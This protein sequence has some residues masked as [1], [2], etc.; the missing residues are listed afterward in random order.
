MKLAKKLLILFIIIILIFS[1]IKIVKVQNIFLKKMYPLEHEEYVDK[2][3]EEFG[4]DKYYI[5]AIIKAESNYD[6]QAQSSK[7]AMGLMQLLPTT[8]TEVANNLEIKLL[9]G[10]L[11]SPEINIMIGTKY[12][13]NLHKIYNN[14]M[15]AIAAYNA[16]PGT[17]NKWIADGSIEE[18]GTNIENIPYKETNMYVRKII[19]NYNIYKQLYN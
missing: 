12:F 14:E 3:S 15:L 1:L 10:T 9:E 18:D 7:G 5:Y 13:A 17:V 2:Y 6:V 8:A 16:G 4:V 11:Y 19:N